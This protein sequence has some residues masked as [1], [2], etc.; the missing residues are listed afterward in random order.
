MP[1]EYYNPID[2]ELDINPLI[3]S[4]VL[5]Y[6]IYEQSEISVKSICY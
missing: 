4:V 2:Y 3:Y 1:T 5:D 6:F